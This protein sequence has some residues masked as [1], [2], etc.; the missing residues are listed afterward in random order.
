V[1]EVAEEVDRVNFLHG[2]KS[3]S[4]VNRTRAVLA[5]VLKFLS[6][7]N[8]GWPLSCTRYISLH[9]YLIAECNMHPTKHLMA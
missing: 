7:M 5:V 1:A 8:Y 9:Q 2:M 3:Q 6:L 4:E